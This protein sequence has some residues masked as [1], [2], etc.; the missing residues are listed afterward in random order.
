M[1]AN[2]DISPLQPAR[3]NSY[4]LSPWMSSSRSVLLA[5][6]LVALVSAGA[7]YQFNQMAE[8]SNNARLLLTQVKEQVS[9]LNSLEWEGIAEGEIDEDL[10]EELA[11]NEKS[12]DVILSELRQLEQQGNLGAIFSLYAEY[13]A[14]VNEALNL[15][16]QGKSKIDEAELDEIDEVYDRLYAD[17]TAVEKGYVAQKEQARQLADVGTFLALA[18]AAGSLTALTH[19]FSKTI[20]DK[21]QALETTLKELQQSQ[22][23][24]IQQEKMAALGQVVAGVAHE[25]NNPLGVIK[26][27]ATNTNQA[28]KDV[29]NA[30]PVLH[31]RLTV[32]EQGIFFKLIDQAFQQQPLALLQADRTLKRKL[33]ADLKEQE[34]S[35]ARNIAD[36]LVDMGIYEN[37]EFLLPLLK[38]E[39]GG[40]AIELAYNLTCSLANNQMILGAV[41]RSSKIVFSLKNYSHFDQ[42]GEKKM[43]NIT[44]GIDTTLAIYHSQLKRNIEVV[45]NY[46]SVPDILGYPDELVQVWTNMIHNAIQAMPTGGTLTIAVIQKNS[47]I[48][49]TIKDTGNGIPADVQQRIFDAFFTTK[50]AGEGSGLGL[51]ISKKIVDKHQGRL[52]VESQPGHT[53]FG[54]WLPIESV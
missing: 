44:E 7:I 52:K 43:M 16:R 27:S 22:N 50:P 26:A 48:E 15:V 10:V 13:K 11:E 20:R 2:P 29:I 6:T 42:S 36:L 51:H 30:L 38:G 47:G 31:Q 54:I 34:I 35:N 46:Q 1:L 3:S 24:L 41:D 12:T 28:L 45:R 40:W 53:Q 25:I 19:R 49:V 32:A 21:N 5:S 33:T 4:Q 9:R 17:V 18:L 8:R 37:C 14:E 39:H 23:H